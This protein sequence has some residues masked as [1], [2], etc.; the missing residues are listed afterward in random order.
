MNS[1]ECRIRGPHRCAVAI[2]RTE[3]WYRLRK[4]DELEILIFLV[5]EVVLNINVGE[6]S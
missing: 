4:K 1:P 2:T 5:K 6:T 3:Y